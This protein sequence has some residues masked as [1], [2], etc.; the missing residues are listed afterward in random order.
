MVKME[1]MRSTPKRA[2]MD[3]LQGKTCPTSRT[4]LEG[5]DLPG[6]RSHVRYS[7]F[8]DRRHVER[9]PRSSHRVDGREKRTGNLALCC[10]G[11]NSDDW[12]VGPVPAAGAI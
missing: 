2:R 3:R 7:V 10:D 5:M 9:F 8:K 1:I 11:V 12:W 6:F 4:A